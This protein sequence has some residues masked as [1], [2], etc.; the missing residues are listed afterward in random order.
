M[1]IHQVASQHNMKHAW[2]GQKG[3][4]DSKTQN[5]LNLPSGKSSQT[6]KAKVV[7]TR[8][9]SKIALG[10]KDVFNVFVV[11]PD[12]YPLSQHYNGP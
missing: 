1:S 7:L 3:P 11:N 9:A 4:I 5:P 2:R 12:V 6:L 8:G 10:G